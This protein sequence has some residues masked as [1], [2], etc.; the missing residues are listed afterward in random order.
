[1]A[2]GHQDDI[3]LLTLIYWATNVKPLSDLKK[4]V[5]T[6]KNGFYKNGNKYN[7]PKCPVL[8]LETKILNGEYLR[9]D[10]FITRQLI[11]DRENKPHKVEEL[12]S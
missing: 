1:M 2:N 5:E 9:I 11:V 6:F 4:A 7:P 8:I 12:N 3:Q 10:G